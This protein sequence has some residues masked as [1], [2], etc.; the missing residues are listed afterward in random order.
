M[1]F[2]GLIIWL[3]TFVGA[4][5]VMHHACS[6]IQHQLDREVDKHQQQLQE[7]TDVR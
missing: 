2:K 5:A 3:V 4:I 1:K 7:Q 6:S